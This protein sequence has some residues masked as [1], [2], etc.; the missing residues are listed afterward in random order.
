MKLA[1]SCPWPTSNPLIPLE[2]RFQLYVHYFDSKIY[3]SRTKICILKCNMAA[4]NVGQ[5]T[6]N[7]DKVCIFI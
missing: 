4:P 5:K 1:L 2:T 6:N 3:L 7:K